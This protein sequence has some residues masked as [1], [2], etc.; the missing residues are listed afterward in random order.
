MH[1]SISHT[2]PAYYNAPGAETW[3]FIGSRDLD[4]FLGNAVKYLVR[5]G[6]K[7][8]S[9]ARADLEKALHYIEK[10][11]IASDNGYEHRSR[12]Q[13]EAF[14][15]LVRRDAFI[16]AH[17]LGGLRAKAVVLICAAST[18]DRLMV[19]PLLREAALHVKAELDEL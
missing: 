8:G 13:Y 2:S 12:H 6:R 7:P 4:Y 5:A 11:I 1:K 14:G 18:A 19:A 15:G 10:R 9:P 3:D 17:G 16:G